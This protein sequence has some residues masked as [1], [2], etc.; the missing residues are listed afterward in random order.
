M[1]LF[2]NDVNGNLKNIVKIRVRKTLNVWEF[3]C[4]KNKDPTGQNRKF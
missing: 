3:Y 1:R 4:I 2:M